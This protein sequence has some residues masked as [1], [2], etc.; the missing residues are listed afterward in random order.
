MNDGTLR[1]SN[2]IIDGAGPPFQQQQEK[3]TKANASSLLH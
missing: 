1:C 2:I 3:G